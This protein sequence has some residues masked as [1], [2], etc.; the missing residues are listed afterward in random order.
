M[1]FRLVASM[2][3]SSDPSSSKMAKASGATTD[4]QAQ[5]KADA[6][7]AKAAFVKRKKEKEAPRNRKG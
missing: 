1:R 5:I 3:S 7:K 2:A 6:A 4:L